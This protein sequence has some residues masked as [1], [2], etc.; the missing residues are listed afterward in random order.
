MSLWSGSRGDPG[1]LR[2]AA[3]A[4]TPPWAP[5]RHP[6]GLRGCRASQDGEG[7]LLAGRPAGLSIGSPA[8]L[9]GGSR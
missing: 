5:G 1:D 3:P 2:A 8:V 6:L 9:L 4:S 7:P